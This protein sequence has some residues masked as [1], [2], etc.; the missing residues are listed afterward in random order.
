MN[1]YEVSTEDQDGNIVNQ[2]VLAPSSA[3]ALW[4]AAKLREPHA[5]HFKSVVITATGTMGRLWW[6]EG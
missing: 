3:D 4:L 6:R 2:D 1:F 5:K